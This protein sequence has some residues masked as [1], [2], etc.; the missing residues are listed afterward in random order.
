M[1]KLDKATKDS[2][3]NLENIKK[4]CKAAQGIYHWLLAMQN[5]YFVYTEVK[6]KRDALILADRQITVHENEIQERKGQLGKLQD[7]L[8]ELKV[9]YKEKETSVRQ[10]QKDIDDCNIQKT[11]AAKLL[12]AL[13]G[14]KQK[15]TILNDLIIQ[16]IEN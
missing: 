15:W 7:K 4:A 5:Y 1:I 10:L 13:Q 2:D 8:I 3:F 16:K 11:R 12:N 6:P 14:E 9:A